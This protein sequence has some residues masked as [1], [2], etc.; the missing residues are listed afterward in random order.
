MIV[1]LINQKKAKTLREIKKRFFYNKKN[2]GPAVC[3][4]LG[5]EKSKGKFICFLTLMI[6][7]KKLF[8]VKIS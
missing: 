7:G 2:V 1:L 4:N 6:T 3:R 8:L 5:L